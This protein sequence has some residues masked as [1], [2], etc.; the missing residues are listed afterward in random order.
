[1]NDT[2]IHASIVGI[3]LVKINQQAVENIIDL[4]KQQVY[5]SIVS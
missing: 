5:Y 2:T 3:H 4:K 1:M